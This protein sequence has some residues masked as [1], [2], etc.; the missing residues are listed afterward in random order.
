[1]KTA[2]T[3]AAGFIGTNLVNLLVENGHEVIAI[4][5][6]VPASP[7]TREAVTWVS[8]D[9][10]DLDSM[11]KALEGVEVVYHLVAVITLEHEDE[12]CWRINTEG[13]RTVA[14]AALTVGARRMVHCSSIDSYSNSVATIDEKS[15]RSTGAD[16]PVYQRSK[17]GGEVAIRETIESGLDAVICN[18]TGVYGP[19]DLPNLSR[20]NQLLFDS[21]RGRLPG[22]VNSQ[23]D[24][25]DARD[26]AAGLYLA[27]EK[28]RTGENYL[29]GGHMGSLLQVC[30]LAARRAGKRGPRFALPMGLLNAAI[31]VIEPI[32]KLLKNDALS[33]AAFNKLT[34]SPAVDITKARTELGYDPR[35]TETTVNEFV[36]FLLGSGRL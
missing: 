8:G 26:V 27:G 24:L 18:P 30:R 4:D 2:V 1:M 6:V 5:R 35:S 29:L 22:M 14:Q 3:G 7:E 17:W 20:I 23:Y 25:V 15:P 19:V 9:V 21:A 34:V 36:D 10:L 16:L 13:A 28:G 32:G 33:R 31:P 12:L 11:T